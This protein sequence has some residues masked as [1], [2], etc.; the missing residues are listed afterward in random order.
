[1]SK[2]FHIRKRYL[3]LMALAIV[4]SGGLLFLPEGTR[5]KELS[6]DKLLMELDDNT[7]F[8][9]VDQLSDLIINQDPSLL[10]VD[11]RSPEEYGKFSLEGALNIPFANILKEENDQYL[12]R[13]EMQKVFY[14]NSDEISDQTW[15]LLRRAEYQNIFVLKGGLTEWVETIMKPVK[16]LETASDSE[17]ELY[18]RRMAARRYFAGGSVEIVPDVFIEKRKPTPV[19]K[20]KVK[21]IPKKVVEEVEE[22]EGC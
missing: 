22:E 18:N 1:M 19:A 9:T 7:R 8:L 17:Q 11:L 10:L 13:V 5:T 4:L 16:P 2:P 20:K 3:F 14:A 12:K 15:I 21:V 6:A